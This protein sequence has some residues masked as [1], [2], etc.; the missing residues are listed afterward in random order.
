[1][2]P[3]ISRGILGVARAG[4]KRLKA[5]DAETASEAAFKIIS[6][7]K[8]DPYALRERRD[9]MNR[10]LRGEPDFFGRRLF[11]DAAMANARF[12]VRFINQRLRFIKAE[13]DRYVINLVYRDVTPLQM[14]WARSSLRRVYEALEAGRP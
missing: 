3:R 5:T 9:L 12:L 14:T 2:S 10:L 13:S 6:A 1:M 4:Q 11:T 7:P 8:P